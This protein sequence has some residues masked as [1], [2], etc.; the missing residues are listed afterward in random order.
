MTKL[1]LDT[2]VHSDALPPVPTPSPVTP[3]LFAE[4]AP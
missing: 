4:T 3:P 1:P 2:V